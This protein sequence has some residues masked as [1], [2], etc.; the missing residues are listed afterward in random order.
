MPLNNRTE[1]PAF[2]VWRKSNP[3]YKLSRTHEW[4]MREYLNAVGYGKNARLDL[5]ALPSTSVIQKVA[6]Y[7]GMDTWS[8]ANRCREWYA[9][10][11]EHAWLH[12]ATD[13]WRRACPIRTRRDECGWSQRDLSTRAGVNYVSI[14]KH[15][16]G[17]NYPDVR[18]LE[19]YGRAFGIKTMTMMR[20]YQQ[21]WESKPTERNA[22]KYLEKALTK[23]ND[24]D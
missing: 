23:D 4:S 19:L 11:P 17:Q 24:R 22:K 1:H 8:L 18:R 14:C 12:H 5:N 6:L 9:L 15:E 3:I 20:E 13:A 10:R 16:R 2:E 7:E 21:W